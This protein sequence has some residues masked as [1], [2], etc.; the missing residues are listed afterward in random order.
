MSPWFLDSGASHHI[1]RV[2]NNLALHS[3]YTGG[4]NVV[5]GN[6][7]GLPITHTGSTSFPSD[8]RSLNLTN[9]LCVP[10]MK[11]NLISVNKLCQTNNVMV[12]LCLYD[13]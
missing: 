6:G 5:I 8:S 3:P 4:E 10:D 11:N 2:L 1:T 13:F 7:A 12:Q 9:I